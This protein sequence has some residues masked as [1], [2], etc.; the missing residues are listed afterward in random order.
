MEAWGRVPR[1]SKS[2]P[3]ELAYLV[4]ARSTSTTVSGS[5]AQCTQAS[6]HCWVHLTFSGLPSPTTMLPNFGE[7]VQ[8]QSLTGINADSNSGMYHVCTRVWHTRTERRLPK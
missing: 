3:G 2:G 4:P 6:N 1:A 8:V 5:G 7:L